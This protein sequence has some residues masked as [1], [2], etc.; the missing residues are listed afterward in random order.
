MNGQWIGDY[1]G[2]NQG[3]LIVDLDEV[4]DHYEGSAM[5]IENKPSLPP[6]LAV[7]LNVPKGQKTFN[8]VRPWC[9]LTG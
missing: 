8:Y 9:P 3:A 4:G 5:A 1:V 2:T 7:L 6:T